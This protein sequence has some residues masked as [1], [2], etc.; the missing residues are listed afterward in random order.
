MVYLITFLEG[1]ITFISPCILP[2]LPVYLLYFAGKGSSSSGNLVNKGTAIDTIVENSPGNAGSG[3]SEHGD[4]IRK[5]EDTIGI[6]AGV[7]GSFKNP[8][9]FVLGFTIVFV[10]LGAFAGTA[11][12]FLKEY[13][14][15]VNLV[16]GAV[17]FI[18]GLSFMGLFR[19]PLPQLKIHRGAAGKSDLSSSIFSDEGKMSFLKA[20]VFGMVFSVAW[21]PCLG[22]FLGAA[23]MLAAQGGNAAKGFTMLL[24]YSLGLGIPFVASAVLVDRLKN[25]FAFIRN[26]YKIINIVTGGLLAVSGILVATGIL[27]KVA[28]LLPAG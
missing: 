4:T 11:G 27:Q 21:T 26:H 28:L 3:G 13:G 18:F 20:V 7:L 22:T 24:F 1:I 5:Y 15:Y 2:M 10:V 19:L 14:F 17:I 8:L 6:S 12:S 16:S 9:G 23:L 25:A